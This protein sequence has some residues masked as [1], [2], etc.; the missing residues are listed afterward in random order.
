MVSV[1]EYRPSPLEVQVNL[2]VY[3]MVMLCTADI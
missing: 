1:D 3:W 2:A